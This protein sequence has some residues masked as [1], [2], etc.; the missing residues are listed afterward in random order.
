MAQTASSQL[1]QT[2]HVKSE[3]SLSARFQKLPAQLNTPNRFVPKLV[4]VSPN[5]LDGQQL[6]PCVSGLSMKAENNPACN[7]YLFNAAISRSR[8]IYELLFMRI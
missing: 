8:V 6:A 5:A 4:R 7:Y 1:S 2:L 3:Q